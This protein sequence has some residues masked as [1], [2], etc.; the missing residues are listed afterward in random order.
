MTS[1]ANMKSV[2]GNGA[3]KTFKF[4][5]LVNKNSQGRVLSLLGAFRG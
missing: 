3:V 2:R 4:C 1:P 5:S